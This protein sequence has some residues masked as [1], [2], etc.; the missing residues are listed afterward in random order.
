VK[1][2]NNTKINENIIE[3][4]INSESQSQQYTLN[5]ILTFD[6]I[7]DNFDLKFYYGMNNTNINSFNNSTTYTQLQDGYSS[8]PDNLLY[9]TVGDRL[10]EECSGIDNL[11]VSEMYLLVLIPLIWFGTGICVI[12]FYCKYKRFRSSYE[13]LR[14]EAEMSGGNNSEGSGNGN[15]SVNQIAENQLQLE[16]NEW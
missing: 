8:L 7:K 5:D 16:V 9:S 13:R 6:H 10:V 2:E 3:Y 14:E 15:N 12:V 4:N 11:Q 1:D